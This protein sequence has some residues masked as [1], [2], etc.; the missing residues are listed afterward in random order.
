[1]TADEAYTKLSDVIE[2]AKTV[3]LLSKTDAEQVFQSKIKQVADERKK[4]KELSK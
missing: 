1:M 3:V 4:I 2:I